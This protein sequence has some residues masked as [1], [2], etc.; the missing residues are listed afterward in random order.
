MNAIIPLGDVNQ[1]NAL[2]AKRNELKRKLNRTPEEDKMLLDVETQ[3]ITIQSQ[4][5]TVIQ[6]FR[7]Y[8]R[9]IAGGIEYGE[10]K[11]LIK[12][13]GALLFPYPYLVY[14]GY[15]SYKKKK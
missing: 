8:A 3:I 4:N 1:L 14:R 10:S 2:Y 7:P 9:I 6:K 11:S 15:Q 12:A 5:K 13:L